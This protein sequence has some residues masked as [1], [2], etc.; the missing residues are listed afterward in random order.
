MKHMKSILSI[1]LALV[2]LVSSAPAVVFAASASDSLALTEVEP[3]IDPRLPELFEQADAPTEPEYAPDDIVRVAIVLKDESAIDEGYPVETIG[4]DK[5]AANYQDKLCREQEKVV[6]RIEEKVL[7]GDDLDVV[8]NL[9]LV[10]NLVS[11][12]V[13]YSQIEEIEKVRGVKEVVIENVYEPLED[14]QTTAEKVDA[15]EKALTEYTGA[16]SRI[17]IIDSG[18][19]DEHQSFDADA[20][21]YS[22]KQSAPDADNN[23][24]VDD[25]ELEA[26]KESLHFMTS[27]RL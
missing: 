4:S 8:T 12:D 21:N 16:G 9:T 2:L 17:A 20:L 27:P 25:N 7:D 19:N 24:T 26:Y 13:E 1:L 11:A 18:V 15:V 6:D 5:A 10:A 3:T 23:G 22:L 14:E